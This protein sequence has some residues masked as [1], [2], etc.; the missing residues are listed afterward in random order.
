MGITETGTR[1]REPDEHGYAT[2]PV[3]HRLAR[4]GAGRRMEVDR[5]GA[6]ELL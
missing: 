4:H 3:A 6:A 2:A 1:T 5:D